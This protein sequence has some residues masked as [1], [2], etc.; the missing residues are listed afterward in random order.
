MRLSKSA[1]IVLYLVDQQK[2]RKP[3]AIMF[4]L[5]KGASSKFI[6]TESNEA[7]IISGCDSGIGL[8]LVKFFYS[9]T[10]Y[11]IIVGLLNIGENV[12][13]A[14]L[15][16]ESTGS[17][18]LILQKLNIT[19]DEDI[20]ALVKLVEELKV[21]GTITS[22]VGLVNN[23][24]ILTYGEFDWLTSSQIED[25]IEVNLKG[26]IRLTRAILPFII[27]SKGRI[28]NVS[29]AYDS[30]VFP[31]LSIYSA[32]KIAIT[33]YSK[34]LGYELR[35]FGVR[36]I[37]M[38]L[39]DFCKLTNIMDKY[40]AQQD[41]MWKEMDDQ[42]KA[43]YQKYFNQFHNHVMENCGITGPKSFEDSPFFRDFKRALL[44]KNP[45]TTITCALIKYRIFYSL[46]QNTPDSFQYR[47]LDITLKFIFKWEMPSVTQ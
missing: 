41:K 12:A 21:K 4:E 42:K 43:K 29:S 20:E 15:F 33:T 2:K 47:L 36:V 38:R 30:I 27:E 44:S 5:I 25:Q 16:E 28:I 1:H 40:R 11:S 22:V 6:Q 19:L 18:R 17:N 34:I 10:K 32:T 24:G 31:G 45:P 23:A 35:K 7:I 13:I 39:G 3:I 9:S 8:Q 37:C 26:T 14:K 46:L